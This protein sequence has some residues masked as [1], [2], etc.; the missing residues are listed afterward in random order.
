MVTVA[1]IHELK[2]II[3]TA[4]KQGKSIGLVPTMGYL[5]EGHLS[6]ARWARQE[7]DSGGD[8]H[9]RESHPNLDPKEDFQSYPRDLKR[10]QELLEGVGV[11]VVFVPE[12]EEVYSS[13]FQTF[14]EVTG[15]FSGVVWPEPARD[16]L[17]G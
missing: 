5:H 6:L 2:G 13:D 15:C 16:I 8:Q 12:K 14:V 3:K 17:K 1:K 9:F 4:R 7:N 10:D 11:E